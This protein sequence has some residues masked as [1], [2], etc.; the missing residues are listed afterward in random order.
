MP[1]TNLLASKPWS[2]GVR[3]TVRCC[4]FRR[5]CEVCLFGRRR[6]QSWFDG[7]RVVCGGLGKTQPSIATRKTHG[8]HN[9]KRLQVG[10]FPVINLLGNPSLLAHR[11]TNR[12][13]LLAGRSESD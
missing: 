7:L 12:R 11:A 1:T 4:R 13:V 3:A 2:E 8:A 6:W 9:A 10:A 5:L